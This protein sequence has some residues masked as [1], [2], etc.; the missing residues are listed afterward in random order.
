MIR[1]GAAAV[2]FPAFGD[3]KVAFG[4]FRLTR[5]KTLVE[6]A[7]NWKAIPAWMRNSR[8]RLISMSRSATPGWRFVGRWVY[9]QSISGLFAKTIGWGW[10]ESTTTGNNVNCSN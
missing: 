2:I 4:A 6:L 9:S 3:D 8:C 10:G 1:L 5:L 7:L